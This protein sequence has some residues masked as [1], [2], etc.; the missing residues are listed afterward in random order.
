M[1]PVGIAL[2]SSIILMARLS[3]LLSPKS[4][5]SNSFAAQF[6]CLLYAIKFAA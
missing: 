2:K 1:L 5:V 3:R 4:M 6:T